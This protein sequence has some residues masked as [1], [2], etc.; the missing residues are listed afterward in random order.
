MALFKK[1]RLQKIQQQDTEDSANKPCIMIVDDEASN[2]KVLRALLESNYQVIE[3]ADGQQALDVINQDPNRERIQLIISD[4]RMPNMDGVTFLANSIPLLPRTKRI[5]LTGYTDVDDIIAAINEGQIYQFLVKPFD[6][7]DILVTVRRALDSYQTETKLERNVE[8]FEKFVPKQFLKHIAPNGIE[9]I[10]LGQAKAQHLSILFAD[11]RSFTSFAE[12]MSPQDL[13]DYLN[14]Y[15][16]QISAPVKSNHGFIDKFIGDAVMALFDRVESPSQQAEDSVK[17]AIAMQKAIVEFDSVQRADCND[18]LR[19][20][21]GIHSGPVVIGTVG[22][23]DRMDSTAL[24]DAVNLASR[25]EGLCKKYDVQIL[26]SSATFHLVQ[27]CD[28]LMWRK[29]DMVKV[30]GKSEPEL[31]YEVFNSES[32]DIRHAK[33]RIVSQYHQALGFF[34]EKEWQRSMEGFQACLDSYPGD[35]ISKMYIARCKEYLINPPQGP[36]DGIY[37]VAG[38]QVE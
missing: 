20:G 3:A 29:L 37:R 31:L 19:I 23:E 13:M 10:E 38:C 21:I 9:A 30:R 25:L 32:A 11:I 27:D 4:Q 26:L 16:R 18:P 36:W 2:L 6:K 22:A 24:G 35:K 17:A 12:T 15:L 7:N 28:W 14:S 1:E 33:A 34:H 5:I 8:V